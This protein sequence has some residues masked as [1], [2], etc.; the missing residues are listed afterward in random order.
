MANTD[1]TLEKFSQ[2]RGSW[3]VEVS[4]TAFTEED[5]ENSN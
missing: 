3:L 5:V 2:R 1:E 4:N